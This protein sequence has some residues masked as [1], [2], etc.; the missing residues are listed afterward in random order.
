MK[1]IRLKEEK[2]TMRTTTIHQQSHIFNRSNESEENKLK[3]YVYH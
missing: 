1:H 3:M 2:K